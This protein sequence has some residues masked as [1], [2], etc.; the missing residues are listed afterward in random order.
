MIEV[1]KRNLYKIL[2]V[3]LVVGYSL[4][5]SSCAS[6]KAAPSG[7]PKDTIPPVVVG[8]K[9]LENT[10][11]FPLDEGEIY[12]AFNEYVQLKDAYKNILLS[13]PLKK[14][15][16]TRIK[17]KG[18][19]VSFQEP[20]DTNQ[21][22]SLNFGNSIV[23]NNESNPL[24]G[25]SY[26]FSTGDAID[27]MM[28]SGKIVDAE[29]LFPIEN[30]TVALYIDAKDSTVMNDLPKAV[31]KTDKWGYFTL[32]NLKPLAYNIFAFS[33]DNNNNK[34]D[35]GAEKIAFRDSTITPVEVMHPDSPQ[36]Q[37]YDPE[38]TTACLARPS[39]VEL[40]IFAEKSNNQFIKDYKRISRRA[41]YIKFNAQDTQIDSFS[42]DG[43]NDEKIIKQFNVIKDSLVFW[44]NEPGKVADTLELAVKYHKTDSSGRLVPSVE[45]L[46]LVAPFEKKDE[47][48]KTDERKDKLQFKI[49]SDNKMVEQN[50][51]VLQFSD[52]L[53]VKKFD[54]L[55]FIMSTPKQ[56]KSSVE[57]TVEQDSIEINKYV[58]RPKVQFVAGNDYELKFP[59]GMFRDINGFTNDSTVTKVTLPN[60]DNA[61]SITL[62]VTGVDARYIVELIND[63]RSTVYRKFVI[64]EDSELLFP[65]LEKG[66]YSIRITQDKN[67]NGLLDTGDLLARRQPEKVLLYTLPGGKDI[68][69]LNE[70]TDLIQS[71][72]IKELFEN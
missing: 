66:N 69:N 61:S 18:I 41:A 20:L 37:N 43:L 17:G 64:N 59:M 48:K 14:N 30:A 40:S 3:L 2:T 22:Y 46:R 24:Y 55:S 68:I 16:K 7:G 53:V 39:E 23:D 65:Y 6:T 71:V 36:L 10:V 51:I 13:P 47:K 38:D 4:H 12:I 9:P 54:T 72:N 42:I 29:T 49:D 28:F 8:A 21:T 62:D 25:Y 70:K 11:N 32:R 31:A 34:Y 5:T 33:D 44:F 1:I 19:V 58:I 57:Y 15:V 60:D 56:I 27:S 52:P 50:G 67:S 35:Q 63:T 26:S 45:K